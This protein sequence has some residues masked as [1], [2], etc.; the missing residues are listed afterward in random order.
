MIPA[1]PSMYWE[2]MGNIICEHLYVILSYMLFFPPGNGVRFTT[3]TNR[4]MQAVLHDSIPAQYIQKNKE[5][6]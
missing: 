6:N 4:D 1:T 2:I 5:L 3:L